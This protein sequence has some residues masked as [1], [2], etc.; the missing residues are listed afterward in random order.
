MI[1]V[2]HVP[3]R[4]N[5]RVAVGDGLESV[6]GHGSWPPNGWHRVFLHHGDHPPSRLFH[7]QVHELKRDLRVVLLHL[8]DPDLLCGTGPRAEHQRAFL[9]FQPTALRSN[10][11][12]RTVPAEDPHVMGR[13][14]M[15]ALPEGLVLETA[16]GTAVLVAAV[17]RWHIGAVSQ[18]SWFACAVLLSA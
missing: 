5:L 15:F 1:R 13:N 7:G 12:G 6:G 16:L 17:L 8:L 11:L 10:A 4:G 9:L 14:Q 3:P 18:T 2:E